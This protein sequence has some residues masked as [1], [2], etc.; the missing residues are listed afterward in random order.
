MIDIHTHILPSI[1]DGSRSVDETFNLLKEAHEAGFTTIVST[2]HYFLGHYEAEEKVRK[3][4]IDAISAL[5]CAV[6]IILLNKLL[7]YIKINN[8]LKDGL[9]IF[10]A[11]FTAVILNKYIGSNI[12]TVV[13][14]YIMPYVPGIAIT[15][16]ARDTLNADYMSGAARLLDAL[17]QAIDVALGVYIGLYIGHL[18]LMF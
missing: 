7:T 17:V 13:V 12:Q 18:F 6:L 5:I 8:F 1:D 2:S 16:A 9:L 4:Y 14:G 3:S 10:V 11:S 15:N